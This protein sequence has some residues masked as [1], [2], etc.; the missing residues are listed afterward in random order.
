MKRWLPVVAGCVLV[1][2][3]FVPSVDAEDHVTI[4]LKWLHGAQFA[5]LYVA[6]A[7]GHFERAG[8]DV[9]L[10]EGPA[11]EEELL[12]LSEGAYDFAFADPSCHLDLV[13][14]GASNVAVAAVFQIDPVV[15]FA[16]EETGIERPED[17]VGKRIMSFPTS[18][19]I[20]AVLGR[21][22]LSA[23]DVE[24]APPSYDL[25]DLYSGE[26]DA[27][28][29][30]MTDEVLRVRADGHDVNVI[31]PTDYGVH[32]YGDVLVTRWALVE[33]NPS[34]VQRVVDAIVDGWAWT[35]GHVEEAASLT[36]RWA[37][38]LAPTDLLNSLRASV[39]FVHAGEVGL[40]GMADEKWANMAVTMAG[41]GLLP[42]D[43]DPA[44]AY[45][46]EFV[47]PPE[48]SAP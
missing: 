24:I 2:A 11:T 13:S 26:Y 28:S 40:G 18:Y 47:R 22:G 6:E 27:W 29:G 19:I 43:L 7:N 32:L 39:P 41:F 21:V 35:L 23:D 30:Y 14:R 45:T 44:V 9:E 15:I 10:V 20:Q 5:G 16:L 3:F 33:T 4:R 1:V 48:P 31:Y 42:E 36:A 8:L 46:L 34:L 25:R 12:A 17:L 38:D 37:S